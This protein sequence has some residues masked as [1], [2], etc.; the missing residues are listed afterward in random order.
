M[1]TLVHFHLVNPIMVGK[2]KTND[3]QFYT[4]ARPRPRAALEHWR[5]RACRPGDNARRAGLGRAPRLP[6]RACP[7]VPPG[8]PAAPAQRPGSRRPA[9][10]SGRSHCCR[11]RCGRV[12]IRAKRA[13]RAPQVTDTVQTV[14]AGRR[15][16]YDP[17]EL[18]EEQREREIRN[19]VDPASCKHRVTFE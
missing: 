1:V 13:R 3:V 19:K 14:D 17:D 18:E 5:R 16:M 15:S 11:R 9:G 6:L 10:A 7:R 4:E 12:R 8:S 2:K